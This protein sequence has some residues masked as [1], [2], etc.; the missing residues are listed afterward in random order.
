MDKLSIEQFREYKERL[1]NIISDA[2]ENQDIDESEMIAKYIEIEKELF[3]FDLSEI[4]FEEWEGLQLTYGDNVQMDISGSHANIDG[5]IVSFYYEGL[6]RP[7]LKGCKV[8]NLDSIGYNEETV[9][10]EIIRDN[11]N[12]FPPKTIPE[13]IRKKYYDH[14]L[15]LEDLLTYP[16]L[17]EYVYKDAFDNGSNSTQNAIYNLGFEN[18][19]KVFDLYPEL[20]NTLLTTKDKDGFTISF[21]Y[22]GDLEKNPTIEELKKYIFEVII[23]NAEEYHSPIRINQVSM[24]EEMKKAHPEVIITED[25]VPKEVVEKY[26][27]GELNL[28]TIIKYKDVFKNKNMKI[29]LIKSHLIKDIFEK[30]K[31]PFALIEKIPDELVPVVDLYLTKRNIYAL[32]DISFDDPNEIIKLAIDF[33][34]NSDSIPLETLSFIVNSKYYYE[35][36]KI[37]KIITYFGLDNVLKISEEYNGFLSNGTLLDLNLLNA[38]NPAVE[39]YY[40]DTNKP[41]TLEYALNDLEDIIYMVRTN[42]LRLTEDESDTLKNNISR[43][44]RFLSKMMPNQ[45]IDYEKAD[46]ELENLPREEKVQAIKTLENGFNGKIS[47]L[48][49]SIRKYPNLIKCFNLDDAVMESFSDAQRY[50]FNIMGKQDFVNFCSLFGESLNSC[51]KQSILSKEELFEKVKEM[52]DSRDKEEDQV[53]TFLKIAMKTNYSLDGTESPIIRNNPFYTKYIIDNGDT[54]QVSSAVNHGN[55]EFLNNNLD[56][57]KKAVQ[58]G[59]RFNNIT[60]SELRN[61]LDFVK[62]A[63]LYYSFEENMDYEVTNCIDKD[64]ILNNITFT[65]DEY[66]YVFKKIFE[67]THPYGTSLFVLN[68]YKKS[69]LHDLDK[70]YLDA[71][72]FVRSKMLEKY[73]RELVDKYLDK[74]KEGSVNPL[75]LKYVSTNKDLKFVVNFG[76][77]ESHSAGEMN[78]TNEV[79]DKANPT[80]IKKLMKYLKDLKCNNAFIPDLAIKIYLTI[81]YERAE[82]LLTGKYGTVSPTI[83][84]DL[85]KNINTSSVLFV[86]DE[87]TKQLVPD[88]N[89]KLI[90]TIFG[91]NYKIPN[92]PIR[93]LISNCDDKDK[94]VEKQ[95]DSIRNDLS[96]NAEQ[97]NAKIEAIKEKKEK[98]HEEIRELRNSFSECFNYYDIF[99]EEFMKTQATSTLDLKFNLTQLVKTVKKVDLARQVKFEARDVELAR[100]DV[101]EYALRDTQ[102]V[103]SPEKIPDRILTLSR[104]MD[105]VKTKCFPNVEEQLGKYTMRVYGP[106]D[107]RLLSAGYRS[108]C[109]F[110]AQG[111]ADDSGRDYSLL[112]YCVSTKYGGG[113]EIVDDTG[114]TIMF[115]PI[116]RNGNVLM[117]HSVESLIAAKNGWLPSECYELFHKFGKKLIEEAY[118]Q[119][120]QIDYVLMTDLHYITSKNAEGVLPLEKKFPVFDETGKFEGMY[121]NLTRNHLII[122][123]NPDKTI[124][125]IHYGSVEHEYEFPNSN[126]V[127]IVQVSEEEKAKIAEID[128]IKEIYTDKANARMIALQNGDEA[129]AYRLLAEIKQDKI[130]FLTVYKDILDGRK[131]TDIYSLY[132][133]AESI[134]KSISEKTEEEIDTKDAKEF[135]YGPDWYIMINKNNEIITGCLESGKDELAD[136][137]RKLTET[138][139]TTAPINETSKANGSEAE[140]G[141]QR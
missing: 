53:F 125:D 45:F 82:H 126:E 2:E 7:I 107:R 13:E 80:H 50:Y 135:I 111:N 83:L 41:S 35:K 38:F 104:R 9:D 1:L 5:K 59:F 30:S 55:I 123:H 131:N 85:F 140:A 100:S 10:E 42:S 89:K 67:N 113:V 114:K 62:Y 34:L 23:K 78:Y 101:F 52:Y 112:N 60:P 118:R 63:I 130:K 141:K 110:R 105:E 43:Q 36:D 117:I 57:L 74:V 75:N 128:Q 65:K 51:Y 39:Q 56:Y 28:T 72:E 68:N 119:G 115:S 40:A 139:K 16:E 20:L 3:K 64:Y 46:K 86:R 24:P 108:G 15:S 90:N 91:E 95:I 138:R 25:E 33:S 11:P 76:D 44:G 37:P 14:E 71:L 137:L 4:P 29:G 121:H 87:K 122:A 66:K 54:N 133:R 124:K 47:D 31:D 26:Y 103:T 96:L 32:V 132:K 116:L 136:E 12:R 58:K 84:I 61:N 98:Y 70:E 6:N 120:D 27:Q 129:E 92:T 48:L 22:Y 21:N 77:I 94:E 73:D 19:M 17:R 127:Y 81:G 97:R 109:C 102:F 99:Y 8:R 69:G 93:N 18:T 106:H 134:V 49:A 79:L 88:I